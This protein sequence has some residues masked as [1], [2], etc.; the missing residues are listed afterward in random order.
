MPRTEVTTPAM[1]WI[2]VSLFLGGGLSGVITG[3]GVAAV[4]DEVRGVVAVDIDL[5]FD[6]VGEVDDAG[7]TGTEE[8]KN[9]EDGFNGLDVLSGWDVII[10][11]DVVNGFSMTDEVDVLD[12]T[13]LA[14][15]GAALED[16]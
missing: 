6:P 13:S 10:V 8:F 5:G 3:W 1:I 14:D 7:M 16:A 15:K 12:E 4:D 2:L 11:L 9:V